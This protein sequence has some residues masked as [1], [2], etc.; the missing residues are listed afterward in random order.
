MQWLFTSTR[1]QIFSSNVQNQKEVIKTS[2]EHI[3]VCHHD[4]DD[5]YDDDYT[6]EEA[7]WWHKTQFILAQSKF[8]PN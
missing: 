3:T 4:D 8:P 7:A 1:S 2:T 6:Q 5:E